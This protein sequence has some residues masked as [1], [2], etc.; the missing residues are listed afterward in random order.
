MK[1]FTAPKISR[2]SVTLGL[3]V[4]GVIAAAAWASS[5]G[6]IGT[7]SNRQAPAVNFKS[8]AQAGLTAG[9]Y[10][11]TAA[12]AGTGSSGGG[13]AADA[14]SSPQSVPPSIPSAAPAAAEP[15]PLYPADPTPKCPYYKYPGG[16]QPMI[17]CYPCEAYQTADGLRYPC[18]CG[19]GSGIQPE[20]LCASP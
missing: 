17:V 13:S 16:V 19:G 15:D 8:T 20:I 10:S 4:L 18:G 14:A 7:A 12:P 2:S 5:L 11:R 9:A 6:G 3:C 1:R